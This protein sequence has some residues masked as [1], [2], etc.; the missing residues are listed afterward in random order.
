MHE[1]I[2]DE[3][4]RAC[5]YVWAPKK[6]NPIVSFKNVYVLDDTNP[7]GDYLFAVF[8]A[9][10]ATKGSCCY[11]QTG[12]EQRDWLFATPRP[13]Q[14][15]ADDFT[16]DASLEE[17]TVLVSVNCLD[18]KYQSESVRTAFLQRL[19]K[20]L[21]ISANSQKARFAVLPIIPLPEKLP[22]DITSLAEREYDYY[23]AHKELTTAEAFYLQ[24]EAL[25]RQYV[26]D[27][28][29]KVNL[30]RMVNLYG[31]GVDLWEGFSFQKLVADSN[32]DGQIVVDQA[33]ATTTVSATY[34]L[35]AFMALVACLKSPKIGN[36]FNVAGVAVTV[37]DIK[38][39]Y[40]T[41]FRD[42]YALSM[43]LQSSDKMEYRALN[44]LKLFKLGYNTRTE[45]SEN[46][47]RLG[48]YY[49]D[50]LY[51]MMRCIPVYSGRLEKIKSLEMEI[52]K[53]VDR[54]CREN[55][56]QY[57][58]AGG[59]LLGA[60][61]HKSI[62]PWDDDLDIGMLREDFEKF[63]RVCPGLMTEQFTYESPQNDS[64]SHYQFD[65]IRLKN[66][67]FSTNYSS[68]FR[69]RDG[70]FFDV[71]IYD[72]T[73]NNATLSKWQIKIVDYWTRALNIRWYN[74]PRRGMAYRQ[75]KLLLPFMRIFPLSFYHWMFERLVRFYSKKKN[76]KYL[77]D[78]IG[79]NIRKGRF[80][81]EWL[82]Q[83]EYVPF[84]DMMAPIPKG[85]DGYLRHFY[86]DRY[87][88]LLP[89]SRRTSGHYIAR[90]DLGGYLFDDKPDASFREVALDGELYEKDV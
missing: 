13:E 29:A 58:L 1:V 59:S 33:D 63:R 90:I 32:T 50:Q 31:P 5:D 67:Y 14:L 20:W 73:S 54:V 86:G 10:K 9:S 85:Y 39:A 19:E 18:E 44:S 88:E 75:S 30:L 87:M 56:I 35:D 4:S 45:L 48:I 68:T 40:H 81:K 55:D 47:Y 49:N 53:F 11:V 27:S 66:T 46:V 12:E 36:V 25:C 77:I 42:K 34:I 80:P 61:R 22:Q 76:A 43:Q 64:G 24:I 52:L 60:V 83:T 16:A 37:C 70:V 2:L 23:L 74:K 69:I 41:A 15:I 84:G 72:Q 89:I 71:I 6:R 79:Q 21:S 57:F 65:K 17:A 78:G 82:T 8:S 28:G 26:R 3:I 51:D 62:I 38:Q 7:F